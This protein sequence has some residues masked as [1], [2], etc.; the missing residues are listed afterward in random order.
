MIEWPILWTPFSYQSWQTI[1]TCSTN[2][3]AY[4]NAIKVFFLY[5]QD[6]FTAAC[7]QRSSKYRQMR[8]QK[9]AYFIN[10]ENVISSFYKKTGRN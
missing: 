5:F 7:F 2:A 10:Y 4:R 9:K 3:N 1:N 8:A 6:N